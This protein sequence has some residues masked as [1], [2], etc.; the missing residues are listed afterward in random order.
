MT[1]IELK[2]KKK[3]NNMKHKRVEWDT[4]YSTELKNC[5]SE[6]TIVENL[7]FL[8][9]VSV[10]VIDIFFLS[11]NEYIPCIYAIREKQSS[12]RRSY[13]EKEL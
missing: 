10:F 5:S 7:K 6:T 9:L 12:I 3:K 13:K 11:K 8:Y 4:V 1:E 2:N